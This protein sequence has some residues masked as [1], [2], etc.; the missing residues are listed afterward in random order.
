MVEVFIY[1]FLLG[2]GANIAIAMTGV[3]KIK[4]DEKVEEPKKVD[5]S[6]SNAL[7][8]EMEGLQEVPRES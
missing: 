8:S 5:Q 3:M 7:S 4:L 1:G 6:I 2:I